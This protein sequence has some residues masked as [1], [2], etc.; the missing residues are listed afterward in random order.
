LIFAFLAKKPAHL[1]EE[2]SSFSSGP[3]AERFEPFAFHNTAGDC[4]EFFVTQDDYFGQR[5][6]DYLTLYLDMDTAG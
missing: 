3:L 1:R 2:F 6:D 5:V 4:I